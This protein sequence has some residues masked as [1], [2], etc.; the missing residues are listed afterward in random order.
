LITLI[1]F[2]YIGLFRITLFLLISAVSRVRIPAP[3]PILSTAWA[4][5]GVPG[6]RAEV[7]LK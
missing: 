5:P 7:I 2:V 1:F 6:F 3:P 4:L